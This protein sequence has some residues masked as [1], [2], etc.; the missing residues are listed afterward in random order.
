MNILAWIVWGIGAGVFLC[1]I[2]LL[3]RS[4]PTGALS[5]QY[6][7]TLLTFSICSAAA[8]AITLVTEFSKLH[9]VWIL[10]AAFG[11]SPIVAVRAGP[12]TTSDVK[13]DDEHDTTS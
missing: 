1:A 13:D 12:R 4:F 5:R 11:I 10:P 6:G 3:V 2:V 9:L 7:R 8:L